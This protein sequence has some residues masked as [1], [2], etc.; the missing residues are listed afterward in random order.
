MVEYM[1]ACVCFTGTVQGAQHY[2]LWG[3]NAELAPGYLKNLL[4]LITQ[5]SY[6][7]ILPRKVPGWTSWSKKFL[8]ENIDLVVASKIRSAILTWS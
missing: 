3:K 5:L 7:R 4:L 2:F 1:C 8:V 6:Y